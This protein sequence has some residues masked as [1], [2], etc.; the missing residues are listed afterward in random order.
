MIIACDVDGVVAPLIQEVLRRY[1]RDWQDTLTINDIMNWDFYNLVKPECGKKVY[2][3]FR[4]PDM[5]ECLV[6]MDGAVLGIQR[7]RDMG[8]TIIFATSC[9]YGMVDQKATWM[10]RYGFC[11]PPKSGGMLP[12]DLIIAT[13]KHHLVADLLIDDAPHT[14]ETWLKTG[15]RAIMMEYPYNKTLD[16]TSAYTPWLRRAHDWGEIIHYVEIMGL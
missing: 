13:A 9:Y 10:E 16:I 4:D 6:P 11:L 3:Y 15:R 1:N 12:D 8:H 7:L 2:D 5:Y 14:I